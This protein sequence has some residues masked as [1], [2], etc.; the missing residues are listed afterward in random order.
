[1]LPIFFSPDNVSIVGKIKIGY[2]VVRALS[3]YGV[4]GILL[5]SEQIILG[6]DSLFGVALFIWADAFG[7]RG[8]FLG[9]YS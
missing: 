2:S 1:M 3:S 5:I 7:V 9:I 8:V 6:V 4:S